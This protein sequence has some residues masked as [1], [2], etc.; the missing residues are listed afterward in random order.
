[1][2]VKLA[3]IECVICGAHIEVFRQLHGTTIEWSAA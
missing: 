1:M 2:P 3:I